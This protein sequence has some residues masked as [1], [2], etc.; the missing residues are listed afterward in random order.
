M[1][2]IGKRGV[3]AT[4]LTRLRALGCAV[5]KIHGS[6]FQ[7]DAVDIL[8]VARCGHALAIETKAPGKAVPTPRQARFMA[9]WGANGAIV[10]TAQSADDAE[11][12]VEE[13]RCELA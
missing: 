13:H 10:G 9:A 11:R 8:G 12:L 7:P 2:E 3:T 5:V 1:K 4:A 6:A